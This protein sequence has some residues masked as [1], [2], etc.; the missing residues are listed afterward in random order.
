MEYKGERDAAFIAEEDVLD[1]NSSEGGGV[2]SQSKVRKVD[3]LDVF[4]ARR[5]P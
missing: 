4:I 3:F 5:S 2:E 1:G